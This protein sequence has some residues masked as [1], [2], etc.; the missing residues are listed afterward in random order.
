VTRAADSI[1]PQ[2]AAPKAKELMVMPLVKALDILGPQVWSVIVACLLGAGCGSDLPV[3][4]VSGTVTLNGQ[5]L[6][7]ASITTQPI[8]VGAEHSPGSGSFAT[9]DGEGRFQLELVQPAVLGAIVGEHRVMITP[10]GKAKSA[11]PSPSGDAIDDPLGHLQEANK[12]WPSRFS[13]GSLRLM[14]PPEGTA[15]AKFELT[16]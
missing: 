3:A 16:K 11:A 13:D 7:G 6:V 9:T 4:P 12:R 8:A 10:G 2:N 14:V 5:P 1:D 15:S